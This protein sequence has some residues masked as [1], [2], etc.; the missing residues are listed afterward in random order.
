MKTSVELDEKKL[1][2]AKKLSDVSTTKDLLDRALDTF[3]ARARRLSM[4]ELLGKSLV[5]GNLSEMRKSRGHSH[6]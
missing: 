3:I 1:K 2:L 6:R 4:A 5:E